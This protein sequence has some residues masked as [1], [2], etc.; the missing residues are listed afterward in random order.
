MMTPSMTGHD[1]SKFTRRSFKVLLNGDGLSNNEFDNGDGNTNGKIH[2]L[3]K[4]AYNGAHAK[5]K[6]Q[7]QQ[8]MKRRRTLIQNFVSNRG[9]QITWLLW[10][11]IR[12]IVFMCGCVFLIHAASC[13]MF[14]CYRIP[15]TT[16]IPG[17]LFN[18]MDYVPV[19]TSPLSNV[20][21]KFIAPYYHTNSFTHSRF[22]SPRIAH[23]RANSP[24]LSDKFGESRQPMPKIVH[25]TYRDINSIPKSLG[26]SMESWKKKNNGWEFRFYS[27]QDV[28][29]FVQKEFPEYLVAFNKLTKIVERADFFRYMVL[30]RHG[31]VYAD[32]DTEIMRPLDGIIQ[33]DDDVIIGLESMSPSSEY[34]F[35]HHF[36]RSIQMLQW[37]I[38]SKPNHPILK[39]VCDHIANNADTVFSNNT[40]I[41]TLMRTGPGPWTDA[42]SNYIEER[43]KKN[44]NGSLQISDYDY[45]QHRVR[46]LP[47]VV[48][49]LN[50]NHA[51][52]ARLLKDERVAVVHHF[53]GSWKHFWGWS[54]TPALIKF[55]TNFAGYLTTLSQTRNETSSSFAS[56]AD[57]NSDIQ[58]VLTHDV[59][60]NGF[61]VSA[62]SNPSFDIFVDRPGRDTLDVGDGRRRH[63][64]VS[65]IIS[66]CGSYEAGMEAQQFCPTG[67]SLLSI[68][69]AAMDE[70][71]ISTSKVGDAE[72]DEGTD[73]QSENSSGADRIQSFVDFDVEMIGEAESLH[74]F[75]NSGVESVADEAGV[76]EYDDVKRKVEGLFID[77]G[78]GLGYYSLGVAA[79]GNRVVAFETPGRLQ[80][81]FAQS[82]EYNRLQDFVEIKDHVLGRVANTGCLI[83]TNQSLNKTSNPNMCGRQDLDNIQL[84]DGIVLG[85]LNSLLME[86][87]S[88]NRVHGNNTAADGFEQEETYFKRRKERKIYRIVA[89]R[90]AA[91]EQLLT[92]L[93]G[94]NS[95]FTSNNVDIFSNSRTM[96][97]IISKDNGNGVSDE[98]IHL[99]Q[100]PPLFVSIELIPSLLKDNDNNIDA[101]KLLWK[102]Y[103]LHYTEIAHKGHVCSAR[104]K[105]IRF[106]QTFNNYK[107]D[108]N[109]KSKTGYFTSSSNAAPEN[110]D[111]SSS[112][113]SKDGDPWC[114]LG[115]DAFYLIDRW[116]HSTRPEVILFKYT[117]GIDKKM[118]N[119][120]MGTRSS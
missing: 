86:G 65:N 31:G 59:N 20:Q 2:V 8:F 114:K 79:S 41:D 19:T 29:E 89:M 9:R 40:N 83:R 106:H 66:L 90:I 14:F 112:S 107:I 21:S 110:N 108:I 12:L 30:L 53:S 105:A 4:Y 91:F 74:V 84:R 64:D 47:R 13:G 52:D 87:S 43:K 22:M 49:G 111:S 54:K 101:K 80:N 68:F 109:N 82:V 116:A 96:R 76:V 11:I 1:G 56:N 60:L 33:P 55:F 27:D 81:L 69:N 36:V 32:L 118:T 97:S 26:K 113:E 37:I 44:S 42:V 117:G 35:K 58:T 67:L 95:I 10:M 18:G 77:I 120:N 28:I 88:A 71:S 15:I 85:D 99:S 100:G 6:T 61:I 63:A 24:N 39:A 16:F 103:D 57:D 51:N 75:D 45:L 102:M 78:A 48:F 93:D 38:I 5:A 25:Q 92:I 72:G 70:F 62:D 104:W 7:A 3:P 119:A 23:G 94:A 17:Q 46:I 98:G 73:N 115:P 50:E 34:A